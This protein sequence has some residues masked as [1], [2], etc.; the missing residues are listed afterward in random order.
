MKELE[1]KLKQHEERAKVFQSKEEEF[2]GR[3]R[4]L[5]KS[6]DEEIKSGKSL[7]DSMQF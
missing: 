7:L 1:S 6:L 3:V 4:E 5:V 2:N